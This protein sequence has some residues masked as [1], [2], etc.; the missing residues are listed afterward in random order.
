MSPVALENVK[1]YF[2]FSAKINMNLAKNCKLLYFP[3]LIGTQ[4]FEKSSSSV[5]GYTWA[6]YEYLKHILGRVCY[7]ND[8]N[9]LKQIWTALIITGKVNF[10][11]FTTRHSFLTEVVWQ[12]AGCKGV[13]CK[14]FNVK[15]NHTYY[16]SNLMFC[17]FKIVSAMPNN[18]KN[19]FKTFIS[20]NIMAM[21]AVFW[22]KHSSYNYF[23]QFYFATFL[24]IIRFLCF[25]RV[26]TG[27]CLTDK[28]IY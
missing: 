21:E 4:A 1:T 7:H 5:L 2:V 27:S 24:E 25:S 12:C 10:S 23:R 19:N 14:Y 6:S 8:G 17:Y 22:G 16:Q 15:L 28:F 20:G 18:P 11:T 26:G 3:H 9:T 13:S